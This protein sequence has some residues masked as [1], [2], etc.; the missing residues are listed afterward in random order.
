MAGRNGPI[1]KFGKGLLSLSAASVVRTAL[2]GWQQGREALA[3]TY[4]V[5]SPFFPIKHGA[6]QKLFNRIPEAPL[7]SVVPVPAVVTLD[8]RYVDV[9]GATPYRDMIAI[10]AI[11][12]SQDPEA[13][14]E[15]GT[16]Y[17]STT[18]NLALNLPAARI[19]TIDLP[20]DTAAASA[21]VQDKPVDD[22]HLI[23]GRQL[24]KSFRGTALEQRITQ[25]Q[26]DSAMYDYS[27]IRDN[28]TV[29]LI[30]GAHTYE[31]ACSDTM[32]SFALAEE[33]SWFLWHDCDV[34]HPGVLRWLVEM[35]DAGL[36]VVRMENTSLAC[37]KIDPNKDP[38]ARKLI[39]RHAG[40]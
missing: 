5:A 32:R 23:Q 6:G 38:A 37:M 26:G 14:L 10:V 9:P 36:P 39:K 18:A 40:R 24:G 17:G 35:L 30:D 8:L 22:E 20:E 4:R 11:A 13:V 34:F 12:M 16:F 15:F 27:V 7:R 21:L 29:F 1:F 25:H 19:H 28:V 2:G 3:E 33:A 31:Y